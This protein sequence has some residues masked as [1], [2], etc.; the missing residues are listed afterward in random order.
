MHY[1][2]SKYPDPRNP[3]LVYSDLPGI[4]SSNFPR[5]EYMTKLSLNCYDFFIILSHNRFK[6]N[7]CYL[8]KELDRLGKKFYFVSTRI[9]EDLTNER[10]KK[11]DLFDESDYVNKAR[12]AS[13]N[14]LTKYSSDHP[15]FIISGSLEYYGK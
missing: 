2:N 3:N 12:I 4:G 15:V 13:K 5:D 11:G 1:G 9:D 10:K 14:S 8:A 7:D 6:E